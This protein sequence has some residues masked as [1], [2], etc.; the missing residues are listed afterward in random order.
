M[1]LNRAYSVDAAGARR[2]ID[3]ASELGPV[4]GQRAERTPD[5]DRFVAEN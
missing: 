3:I 1:S 4:F 5:E 2:P